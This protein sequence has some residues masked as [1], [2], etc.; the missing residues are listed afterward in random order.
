MTAAPIAQEAV[1]LGEGQ[2]AEVVA[3]LEQ[4]FGRQPVDL[5]SPGVRQPD[6]PGDLVEGLPRGVVDRLPDGGEA[7]LVVAD[8]ARVPAAHDQRHQ[9]GR[10]HAE[11]QLGGEDVSLEVV[12]ADER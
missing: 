5:G 4:G 12:H 3:L 8:E 6:E 7:V 11:L 1:Y 10:E 2:V 9:R